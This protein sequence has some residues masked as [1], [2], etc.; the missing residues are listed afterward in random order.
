MDE[1]RIRKERQRQTDR[2]RETERESGT[3][4]QNKLTEKQ[5]RRD[6]ESCAAPLHDDEVLFVLW[7]KAI[8]P[9]CFFLSTSTGSVLLCRAYAH[10]RSRA[11]S[12]HECDPQHRT[13]TRP[14]LRSAW[15]AKTRSRD[16]PAPLSSSP[17]SPSSSSSSS[18][19]RT[20]RRKLSLSAL[21]PPDVCR[22]YPVTPSVH[23][24][25]S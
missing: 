10:T 17:S 12:Q 9:E 3:K 20:R 2:K 23:P 1:E 7:R 4:F 14:L 15:H 16:D 25:P 21:L 11:C 13:R 19:R 5:R 24:S 6:G 22:V 8:F 18:P